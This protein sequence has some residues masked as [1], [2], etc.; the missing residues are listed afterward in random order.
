[1]VCQKCNNVST[2]IEP[3][4]DISLDLESKSKSI[5]DCL[6]RFT[7]PEHLG[8]NA[9]IKCSACSTYQESTKKLSLKTLPIVASLHLKRFNNSTLLNKKR[10]STYISFPL[11]LDLSPFLSDKDSPSSSLTEDY[12]YSLYGVVNYDGAIDSG[13]YTAFVRHQKG[14][15]VECD[16]DNIRIVAPEK[17]LKSEG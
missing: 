4:W 1:M 12:R 6:E 11:E 15:W 8:S 10:I 17:V 7:R 14:V 9:K 13:H 5:N 3:F 16:D 2:T